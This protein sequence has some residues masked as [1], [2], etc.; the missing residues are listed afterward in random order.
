LKLGDDEFVEIKDT[1]AYK[2]SSK[3]KT[4][5]EA[6]EDEDEASKSSSARNG[7]AANDDNDS[8]D[9]DDGSYEANEV[10]DL[11]EALAEDDEEDLTFDERFSNLLAEKDFN[12]ARELLDFARYNEI[13][14]DRYHCERLRLLKSMDDED[15]FYEYYYEIE[16]KI[17]SFPPK[18]QTEISQFV[19]QLAQGS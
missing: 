12:F 7:A 1:S 6:S 19:V 14:D 18:L 11:E 5:D 3:A 10:L 16:S 15:G 2:K 4:D 9:F 13:N 8:V 17:P